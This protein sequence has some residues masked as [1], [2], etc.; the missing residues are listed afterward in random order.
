MCVY[1]EIL[2]FGLYII[3]GLKCILSDLKMN[4]VGLKMLDSIFE[5]LD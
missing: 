4:F 1:L 5:M 2:S 3:V